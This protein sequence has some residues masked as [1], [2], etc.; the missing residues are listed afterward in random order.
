M[1]RAWAEQQDDT[2]KRKRTKP[3]NIREGTRERTL[4][5]HPQEGLRIL[6]HIIAREAT[7]QQ[8]IKAEG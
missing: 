1:S 5:S 3:L 7:R 2:I 6:A 4:Q 8:Q